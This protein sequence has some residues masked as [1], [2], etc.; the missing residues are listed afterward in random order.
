MRRQKDSLSQ[1]SRT[2]VLKHSLLKQIKENKHKAGVMGLGELRGKC[3][4]NI[5]P[6]NIK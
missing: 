3:D 4:Q 1:R 5:L 2:T 6:E